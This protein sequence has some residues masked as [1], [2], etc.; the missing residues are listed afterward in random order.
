MRKKGARKSSNRIAQ[1]NVFEEISRRVHRAQRLQQTLNQMPDHPVIRNRPPES[2]QPQAPVAQPVVYSR[3]INS[4]DGA[5]SQ[6]HIHAYA[7]MK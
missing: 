7:L 6:Q 3:S 2:H 4:L 5:L 1:N